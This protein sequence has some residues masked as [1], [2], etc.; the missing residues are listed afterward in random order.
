MSFHIC[1]ESYINEENRICPLQYVIWS[2]DQRPQRQSSHVI[3]L[4]LLRD[5]DI[6]DSHELNK[7]KAHKDEA[8][9]CFLIA[10]MRLNS[11]KHK[12]YM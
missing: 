5:S 4:S 10:F 1:L 9:V 11:Q 7:F 3:W 8:Q 2:T 12:V 6:Q